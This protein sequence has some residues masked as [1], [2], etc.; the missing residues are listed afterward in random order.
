[1]TVPY[2]TSILV[3]IL[4]LG[5]ITVDIEERLYEV[6][7]LSRRDSAVARAASDLEGDLEVL[8][9]YDLTA[10]VMKKHIKRMLRNFQER[11]R[12]A[13]NNYEDECKE[14]N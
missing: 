13:H 12:V 9:S 2:T 14:D 5:V 1:M 7:K 10:E 8:I 11:K 4:S 3:D 6:S